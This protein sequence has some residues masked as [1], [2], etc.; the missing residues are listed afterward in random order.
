MIGFLIGNGLFKKN[1]Y[2]YSYES[3]LENSFENITHDLMHLSKVWQKYNV[4]IY[5]YG[6]K[7]KCIHYIFARL[8]ML[9]LS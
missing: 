6:S 9:T 1:V 8:Y 2:L 3:L 7:S 4:Y 5:Y